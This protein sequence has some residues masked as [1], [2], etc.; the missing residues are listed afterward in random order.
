MT[1]LEKLK[2]FK[3]KFL[4][5]TRLQGRSE[6]PSQMRKPIEAALKVVTNL[7]IEALFLKLGEANWRPKETME[8]TLNGA[9]FSVAYTLGNFIDRYVAASAEVDP[10]VKQAAPFFEELKAVAT[11]LYSAST[12]P[13]QEIGVSPDAPLME[14]ITRA[15]FPDIETNALVGGL[16]TASSK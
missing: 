16:M 6:I 7:Q 8:G 1:G 4:Q 13:G 15:S 10:W 3:E 14:P 9:M 5:L 12:E 2:L 11:S